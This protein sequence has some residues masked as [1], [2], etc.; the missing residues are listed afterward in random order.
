MDHEVEGRRPQVLSRPFRA[1]SDSG[2]IPG[3][4]P[5]AVLL[6]PFRRAKFAYGSLSHTQDAAEI[7]AFQVQTLLTIRLNAESR[8]RLSELRK[9]LLERARPPGKAQMIKPGA[10]PRESATLKSEALKGRNKS[11]VFSPRWPTSTAN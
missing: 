1:T 4:L 7:F 2:V 10:T 9:V 5:Q 11:C 3:A 8:R 6:A